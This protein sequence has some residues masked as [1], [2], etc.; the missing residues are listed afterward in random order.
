MTN[1]THLV[2]ASF[3]SH[4]PLSSSVST[5]NLSYYLV[6]FSSLSFLSNSFSS[7]CFNLLRVARRCFLWFLFLTTF[8]FPLVVFLV[9][10]LAL[11]FSHLILSLSFLCSSV[12]ESLF[13]LS[14][15][16]LSERLLFFFGFFFIYAK[17]AQ[18]YSR[19]EYYGCHRSVLTSL[20][21][22]ELRIPTGSYNLHFVS[23]SQNWHWACACLDY[24]I[25]PTHFSIQF[26]VWVS[27]RQL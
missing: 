15:S 5:V 23:N 1:L 11:S 22:V 14:F 16:F 21:K 17:A 4:A 19:N 9:L 10:L 18:A 24:V 12:S 3:S 6:T 8:S 20:M 13:A 2:G 27:H 7:P 25:P 26:F